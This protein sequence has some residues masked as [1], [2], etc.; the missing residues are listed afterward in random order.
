[1]PSCYH[2]KAQPILHTMYSIGFALQD[3]REKK[4]FN[5]N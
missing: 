5:I 2:R 4:I 1:M 3:E